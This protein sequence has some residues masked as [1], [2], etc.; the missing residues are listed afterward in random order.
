MPKELLETLRTVAG[1]TSFNK[2][3]IILHCRNSSKI[4]QKNNIILHCRNSSKIQQK[5]NIILHCRN[6][7]K[8]QQKNN[9]ILRC[10][11]SSKIKYKNRR[12]PTLTYNRENHVIIK[13][14]IILN[15]MHK[16]YLIFVTLKL[17]YV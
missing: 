15:I 11:N 14:D 4:Q 9:I 1:Q 10:R 3:N 6:S 7:S 13:S 5:N 2:N 8:I 17:S 12:K 16:I